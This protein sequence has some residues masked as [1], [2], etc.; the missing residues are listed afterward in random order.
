MSHPEKI[1]CAY[2]GQEKTEIRFMI[3]ATGK[4]D[5]EWCM[6]EGTGKMSC[7][8]CHPIAK[9]EAKAVIDRL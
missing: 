7:P 8:N 6:H 2:C 9:A 1:V 3:G 5:M 4:F